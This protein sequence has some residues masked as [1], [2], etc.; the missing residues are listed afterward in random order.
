MPDL[1][2]DAMYEVMEIIESSGFAPKST[3]AKKVK[4]KFEI[5][6]K[7]LARRIQMNKGWKKNTKTFKTDCGFH[8]PPKEAKYRHSAASLGISQP[9]YYSYRSSSGGSQ[10]YW[11]N[12]E[13]KK[14]ERAIDVIHAHA[15]QQGG[16][17]EHGPAFAQAV[18]EI[19]TSQ[20]QVRAQDVKAVFDDC[21]VIRGRGRKVVVKP[22]S[23][24]ND[25][26]K[27]APDAADALKRMIEGLS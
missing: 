13:D 12:D 27:A 19:V 6:P 10:G 7:K 26:I 3:W 17:K 25:Y 24:I 18:Y 8:M 9:S 16:D 11:W 1:Q 20:Y 21:G 22:K 4:G 15:H 5:N 2:K 14:P 23:S